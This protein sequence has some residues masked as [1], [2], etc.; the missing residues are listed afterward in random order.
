[1]ERNGETMIYLASPYSHKDPL[2][3]RT[4]FLLVEQ[5]TAALIK[6]G[7]F[8]WS[9]I[10]H[11]HEMATKYAM[12]T[13]AD[14]WKSYNFDFIRR[15]DAV[16]LLAISGWDQSRGVAMELDIARDL[17]IPVKAVNEMGDFLD[18]QDFQYGIADAINGTVARP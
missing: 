11:C 16:W 15:A 9:P 6:Q 3:V 2:I 7:H 12:P 18:G 14:F 10:V 5:A 1:M 4:R 17:N 8:V 13:D